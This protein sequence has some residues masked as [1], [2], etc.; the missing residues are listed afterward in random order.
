MEWD[1][2]EPKDPVHKAKLA[3]ERKAKAAYCKHIE[4]EK[5]TEIPSTPAQ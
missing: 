2:S 4:S 3:I 5:E 1:A